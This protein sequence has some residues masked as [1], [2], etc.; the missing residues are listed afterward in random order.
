MEFV[1]KP[2]HMAILALA[3]WMNRERQKMINYLQV[4][5]GV[6]REK[7]GKNVFFSM[8]TNDDGSQ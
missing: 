1:L 6:L 8:M 7:F 4:K 2:W 5:N 3:S